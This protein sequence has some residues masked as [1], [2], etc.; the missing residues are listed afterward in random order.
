MNLGLARGLPLFVMRAWIAAQLRSIITPPVPPPPDNL[1][2]FTDDPMALLELDYLPSQL[3]PTPTVSATPSPTIPLHLLAMTTSTV[4]AGSALSYV[5]LFT[6]L[7]SLALLAAKSKTKISAVLFLISLYTTLVFVLDATEHIARVLQVVYEGAHIGDFVQDLWRNLSVLLGDFL[8]HFRHCVVAFIESR[9][10][11]GTLKH[12]C[13]HLAES[14]EHSSD[15]SLYFDN[16]AAHCHLFLSGFYD[17][18]VH[19]AAFII[20]I[21]SGLQQTFLRFILS[22]AINLAW[23]PVIRPLSLV[24]ETFLGK[25]GII[26]ALMQWRNEIINLTISLVCLR[27]V[28]FRQ[29]SSQP[30]AGTPG[31]LIYSADSKRGDRLLGHGPLD[32]STSTSNSRRSSGNT[33]CVE[34][35][36]SF[37]EIMDKLDDTERLS[38]NSC[39]GI[40]GDVQAQAQAHNDC[41]ESLSGVPS[42]VQ[43]AAEDSRG[44]PGCMELVLWR[45]RLDERVDDTVHI[46]MEANLSTLGSLCERDT[47]PACE[48]V[49][50]GF[51]EL[52]Y[53]ELDLEEQEVDDPS[54]RLHSDSRT[55]IIAIWR[56]SVVTNVREWQFGV[57][58]E[59]HSGPVSQAPESHS[60]NAIVDHTDYDHTDLNAEVN[61]FIR[62]ASDS[63]RRSIRRIVGSGPDLIETPLHCEVS[64]EPVCLSTNGSRCATGDSVRDG[65]TD[66]ASIHLLDTGANGI[67]LST[68]RSGLDG[69]NV[70]STS[71]YVTREQT[72][73]HA[74]LPTVNQG[75][76]FCNIQLPLQLHEDCEDEL[77]ATHVEEIDDSVGAHLLGSNMALFTADLIEDAQPAPFGQHI[78]SAPVPDAAL[79]DDADAAISAML[80]AYAS[81]R[82][83]ERQGH[84]GPG[85]VLNGRYHLLSVLGKG[86]FGCVFKACDLSTNS[87]VAVKVIQA[88]GTSSC[89]QEVASLLTLD[90][91]GRACNDIGRGACLYILDHFM[92]SNRVCIVSE[93]LGLSL[94][95]LRRVNSCRPFP[96]LHVQSFA[97]QLCGGLSFVHRCGLIHGDLKPGNI[98]LVSDSVYDYGT[99]EPDKG[100]LVELVDTTIRIAD[101][102]LS[103]LCFHQAP[104]GLQGTLGYM[105]PEMIL[106]LDW[107]FPFDVFSLGCILVELFTGDRLFDACDAMEYLSQMIIVL[108]GLPP[109]LVPPAI[110]L[111]YFSSDGTINWRP[112]NEATTR[113][114]ANMGPWRSLWDIVNPQTP[115]DMQFYDL[116]SRMLT[117]D[118]QQRITVE[119]AQAHPY[120]AQAHED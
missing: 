3:T 99:I 55:C 89:N 59:S 102:G 97:Y 105:S 2:H 57:Y 74:V 100:P 69:G 51:K 84:I 114:A 110:N 52:P 27:E 62:L 50:L 117:W 1:F 9:K 81:Q 24:V 19:L 28:F 109:S 41:I 71:H 14:F 30:Q 20:V 46:G 72:W 94:E 48:Q 33:T 11:L 37:D 13:L 21:G 49:L 45:P 115:Q 8:G 95:D 91:W 40:S 18:F 70:S 103:R 77:E 63:S 90:L 58:M 12:L 92:H 64:S 56:D 119:E 23:L 31:S 82:R 108:G 10:L 67:A 15:S 4:T 61:D 7:S 66:A 5:L 25:Y 96:R 22:L 17:G 73:S 80:V 98:L 75:P 120:F 87:I 83:Y 68:A 60:S 76:Q 65:N 32:A 53:S 44:L 78:V 38:R 101:F 104:L 43:S 35:L 106:G 26:V 42:A 6:S 112:S 107:S 118:A 93:F 16:A 85:C 86:A 29:S 113:Y 54:W 34:Q 111:R 47:S 36:S 88:S 39:S 79:A 116:V